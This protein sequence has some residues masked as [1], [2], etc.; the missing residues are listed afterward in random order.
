MASSSMALCVAHGAVGARVI[1][2]SIS[3]R[4]RVTQEHVFFTN[5]DARAAKLYR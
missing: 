5:S 1:D 2:R 3:I 4:S